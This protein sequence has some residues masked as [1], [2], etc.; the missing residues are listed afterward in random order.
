MWRPPIGIF[1]HDGL[2][3]SGDYRIQLNPRADFAKAAVESLTNRTDYTFTVEDVQFYACIEKSNL[4]A[5][6]VD[7]LYLTEMQLQT[8]TLSTGA[9]ASNLDFSVPP[10]TKQIAVF[11]QNGAAGS[12]SILPLTKLKCLANQDEN[13]KQLQITYANVN[14][15]STNWSS[16]YVTPK[17]YL[18]QRYLDTILYS[19]MV[20]SEGGAESFEEWKKRGAVYLFDFSRDS[21]DRSSHCQLQMQ[22]G[23]MEANTN[24]FVCSFYTRTVEVTTTNGFISSV[25]SLSI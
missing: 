3:G 6:A 8:K 22:F 25:N 10:S 4:A 20:E 9:D 2:L 17:N 14:K 11:V 23:N 16:E 18:T 15:P 13:L 19:G 1:D 21:E 5:T 7:R 24:V 12:N